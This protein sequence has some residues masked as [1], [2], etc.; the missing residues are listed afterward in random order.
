MQTLIISS[1]FP[2][3]REPAKG[4]F[5]ID[6]VSEL[7]R[8]CALKVIAPVPW[9]LPVRNIEKWYMFSKVA[10]TEIIKGIETYHPQYLIIP[11]FFRS[12][13]GYF[14]FLGIIGCVRKICKSS[15]FD[16]IVAYFAYPDGFAAAL[17]A[18]LFKKPLIIYA[19]GSDI[20][21][22]I[23]SKIKRF[24]TKFAFRTATRIIAVSNDL[25]GKIIN[26]GIEEPKVTVIPNGVDV[27]KFM[28]MD[29]YSCRE[30]LSLPQDKK[31]ILFVGA[32]REVKGVKYLIE[33][34]AELIK[35]RDNKVFLAIV[36]DGELKETLENRIINSGLA[37][38]VKTEGAKLHNEIPIWINACDVFCLP[39]LSEGCPN[40]V[41]EALACGKPVVATK[42][43]G[44]PEIIVS[45]EYGILVP[46]RSPHELANALRMA[47]AKEWD[48][49]VLRKKINGFTWK[50]NSQKLYEEMTQLVP[51][52]RA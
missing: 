29:K 23:K 36:G 18:K 5:V 9:S 1:I 40:V 42:V 20:N 46:P 17:L 41:L 49:Q 24:L 33:A 7:S 21:V 35:N 14:Y 51:T 43:G 47:I 26:L 2:N 25:K 52:R 44:L 3:N 19:L 45:E 30:R 6:Q 4:T 37:G 50:E 8:L 15:K 16:I 12:L 28:P 11:K 10:K 27:S 34:F 31:I 38:K 48:P 22:F 39:S 32:I 13:Y